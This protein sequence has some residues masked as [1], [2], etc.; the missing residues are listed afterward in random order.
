VGER[1]RKNKGTR[2]SRLVERQTTRLDRALED[3]HDEGIP[4]KQC[5]DRTTARKCCHAR[6][7]SSAT[8]TVVSRVLQ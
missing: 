4:D 5:S 1:V 6:G 2:R 8:K 7:A 3:S